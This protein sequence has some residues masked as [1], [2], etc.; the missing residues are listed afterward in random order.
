M[1]IPSATDWS[2][3]NLLA[4]QPSQS[5]V[6]FS[7]DTEEAPGYDWKRKNTPHPYRNQ[8]VNQG[9]DDEAKV[10]QIMSSLTNPDSL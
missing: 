8:R 7:S 6:G 1:A 5:R 10:R 3:N 4:L 9:E 2:Y